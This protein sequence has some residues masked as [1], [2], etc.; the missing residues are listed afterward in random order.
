MMKPDIRELLAIT[1]NRM[2]LN[3]LAAE[4]LASAKTLLDEHSFQLCL[5]DM[6]LPDG[7]GLELIEYVQQTLYRYP[8]LPC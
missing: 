5:T 8:D 3:V 7:N 1:I 2:G 4:T 6:R